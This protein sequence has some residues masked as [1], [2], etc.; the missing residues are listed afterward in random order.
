MWG[1]CAGKYI[2]SFENIFCL[3]LQNIYKPQ[4]SPTGRHLSTNPY[5]VTSQKINFP[6]SLWKLKM[7]YTFNSQFISY[8]SRC[9]SV[10]ITTK[11][12]A[13]ATEESGF[14]FRQDQK[15]FSSPQ[16]PDRLWGQPSLLSNG[17][18]GFSPE[19]KRLGRKDN[20]SPF[21]TWRV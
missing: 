7:W 14:D 16:S 1:A 13:W 9:S 21:I 19:V 20:H 5:G 15:M 12:R 17:Y 18:G 11:L 3:N 6:Y 10:G 8:R 4:A 2:M